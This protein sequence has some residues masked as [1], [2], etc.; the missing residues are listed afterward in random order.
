[1]VGQGTAL[2]GVGTMAGWLCMVIS[3]NGLRPP[4]A[5]SVD[6]NGIPTRP[7]VDPEPML[8]DEADAVGLDDAV[9]AVAQVPDAVPAMPAPSN[10]GVGAD[11]PKTA[12][13]ADDVPLIEPVPTVELP[14]PEDAVCIDPAVEHAVAAVVAPAADGLAAVGLMPGVAS[15]VAPSGMPVM[16]TGAAVPMPSGD[17][18]PSGGVTA[19]TPTCANAAQTSNSDQTIATIRM[20]RMDAS[21]SCFGVDL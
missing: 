6:P 3:G 8:G 7:T 19:P 9:P 13:V 15:S 2:L 17:V 1:V 5:S 18:T 16:P 11:V 4:V 14:N 20:P 21:C 12:P 10:N